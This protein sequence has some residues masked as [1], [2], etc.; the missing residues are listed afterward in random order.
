MRRNYKFSK[1]SMKNI[2]TLAKPLQRICYEGLNIANPRKVHCPDFSI[3]RG[4]T[5]AEKQHELYMIGRTKIQHLDH[6]EY[7]KVGRTVTNCDGYEI[8]SDHQKTDRNGGSLAF[9]FACWIDGK[10]NYEDHN[11]ALVATCFME[12]ASNEGFVIDWGGNYRSISDGSH[13]SLVV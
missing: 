2:H 7:K 13:I 12:A 9:D 10:S 6:V 8:K 4:L 11:M 1:G 5:T 3:V